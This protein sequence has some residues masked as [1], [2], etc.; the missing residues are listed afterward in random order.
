ME[1]MRRGIVWLA[2]HLGLEPNLRRL[3]RT[4]EPVI[5]TRNRRDDLN[6]RVVMA[7]TLDP[8]SNCIDIGANVGSILSEIV[9]LAPRG[10]HIAYEPLPDLCNELARRFPQVEVRQAAVSDRT[11]E[12]RFSRINSAP[13][14]SGF[15]RRQYSERDVES[16]A[17]SVEELDSSLPADY[18]PALIKLDVEGAE[19]QVLR[20]AIKTITRHKPIVAFEHGS[21]ANYYG[22]TSA[23]IFELLCD[24]AGLRIFDLDG[25]GPYTLRQFEY[26]ASPQGGRWNF[27][28]RA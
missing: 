14:V 12:A 22:T 8:D 11:G 23:D 21:A 6:L 10:R 2:N 27:F 15:Q 13:E 25:K 24:E 28:A 17:V 4:L 9:E 18:V 5:A 20:G 3:Q 26:A 19:E 1:P 7:A 16:M